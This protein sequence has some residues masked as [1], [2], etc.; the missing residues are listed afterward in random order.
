MLESA[1]KEPALAQPNVAEMMQTAMS[2]ITDKSKK[3]EK[4]ILILRYSRLK[5]YRSKFCY[6]R[7]Q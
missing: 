2:S 1:E 6:V 5:Y 7:S 4:V 3:P